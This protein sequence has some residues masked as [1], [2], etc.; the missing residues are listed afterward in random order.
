MQNLRL[1]PSAAGS[2]CRQGVAFATLGGSRTYTGTMCDARAS[3]PERGDPR[4]NTTGTMSST[5]RTSFVR[6]AKAESA[7]SYG[8]TTPTA[9]VGHLPQM[10]V[11]QG[12]CE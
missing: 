2:T 12:V 5:T 1:T 11:Q 8:C 10:S 9:P 4:K 6:P 3:R 7:L